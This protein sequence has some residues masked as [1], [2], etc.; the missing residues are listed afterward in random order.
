M[1]FVKDAADLRFVRFNRAGE[2]LLGYPREKLI[3]KNDFD[4]FPREQAEFFTSR[5]RAVLHGNS[6]VDIPE[7][8]I[9]TRLQGTRILHTRKIPILDTDGNPEYLLGISEDITERKK[10]DAEIL[11]VNREQAALEER[12]RAL[13]RTLFLAEAST[14][15]A[16]SLDYHKTLRKLAELSVTR[17]RESR[18]GRCPPSRCI[19][20]AISRGT[21]SGL[22]GKL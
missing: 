11:R 10:A 12:E 21:E 2:N 15:L 17:G 7:E 13:E 9:E 22:S 19:D 16:S 5:D 14:V 8:F 4:F 1:V 18:K 6:V 20:A 3:G